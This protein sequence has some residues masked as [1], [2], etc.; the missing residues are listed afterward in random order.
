MPAPRRGLRAPSTRGFRAPPSRLRMAPIRAEE[1]VALD[2]DR[3]GAMPPF[4]RWDAFMRE[5]RR[6]FRQGEHVTLVGTTGSGKTT[7]A[8]VGVLPLRDFMVV[9]ATKVRDE[10]LYDPLL[11]AGYVM[12]D[13][14]HADDTEHPKVIFRPR[15]GAP[16]AQAR[17]EQREA[18]REALVDIFGTGGWSIYADEV[19]YLTQNLGL[20]TEMELLWLQGRSLD[21]S[22]VVSTQ[23]P[24]SIP[25]LAFDQATHLFLFR[26]TD[27]QNVQRMAEFTG[28]DV[29]LARYVIPRLPRHEVLYVDTRTGRMVRTRV[30]IPSRGRRG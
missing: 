11:E 29:D 19:R 18:F 10:S 23:R 1:S 14:F 22:V 28:G 25:L 5:F 30:Q 3:G 12:V 4:Q 2:A 27:R 7:L 6:T 15:L 26:N 13:R 16:T 20:G 17:D 21:V 9:L 8:R 24:V